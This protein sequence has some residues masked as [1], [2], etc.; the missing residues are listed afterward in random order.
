MRKGK[1]FVLFIFIYLFCGSE[2]R[3]RVSLQPPMSTLDTGQVESKEPCFEN[4]NSYLICSTQ[5]Y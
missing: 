4:K 5:F 3:P 1:L 2:I